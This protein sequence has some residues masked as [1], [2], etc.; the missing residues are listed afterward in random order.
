LGWGGI[1]RCKLGVIAEDIS[2]DFILSLETWQRVR[3]LL[4]QELV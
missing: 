1:T 3:M 2:K 4:S